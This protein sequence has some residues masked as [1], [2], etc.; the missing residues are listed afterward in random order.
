MIHRFPLHLY[1]NRQI[2]QQGDLTKS[3]WVGMTPR[4]V[5]YSYEHIGTEAAKHSGR[6]SWWESLPQSFIFT[7]KKKNHQLLIVS[8]SV[9]SEII[10]CFRSCFTF[11]ALELRFH[12][13]RLV[14]FFFFCRLKCSVLICS[15]APRGAN[16][17]STTLWHSE[18]SQRGGKKEKIQ[19]MG[20]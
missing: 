16:G 1:R 7:K 12:V 13:G 2:R 5:E 10:M 19:D 6:A 20:G 4:S 14:F 8:S 9:T 11:V 15:V 3:L 17:N 18:G